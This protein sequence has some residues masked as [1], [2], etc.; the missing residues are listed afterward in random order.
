MGRTKPFFR[1]VQSALREVSSGSDELMRE[2]FGV[3]LT[4]AMN[5]FTFTFFMALAAADLAGRWT[6]SRVSGMWDAIG[7]FPARSLCTVAVVALWT[8]GF[9][10]FFRAIGW[11]WW[12]ALPVVLLVLCPATWSLN[13]RVESGGDFMALFVL[14]LPI[15]VAYVGRARKWGRKR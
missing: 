15:A 9:T 2:S 13:H 5:A 12:W 4:A 11:P 7:R 8:W 3:A 6:T 14:Q 10:R 1:H